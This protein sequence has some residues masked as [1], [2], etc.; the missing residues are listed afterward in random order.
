M[1]VDTLFYL[2]MSR[3]TS[4]LSLYFLLPLHSFFLPS[5][6]SLPFIQ[7]SLV[8]GFYNTTHNEYSCPPYRDGSQLLY[9]VDLRSADPAKRTVVYSVDGKICPFTLT[10]LPQTVYFAV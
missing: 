4:L 5:S 1:Y 8:G 9:Q 7:L 10:H 3:I 6:H 2:S